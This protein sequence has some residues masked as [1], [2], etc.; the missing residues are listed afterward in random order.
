MEGINLEYLDVAHLYLFGGVK[1]VDLLLTLMALDIIT[2]LFKAWKNR[3]LWSRKSLFGYAR[4]LLVLIVIITA[5]IIDQVLSLNGT[6]TF[7][8]VLFYVANEAL[9]ITENMAQLGVL[10]PQNLAEKLKVIESTKHEKEHPAS[11]IL[12]ELAGK[13]VNK[14]LK[15]GEEK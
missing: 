14:K 3:N 5:N 1:F 7:A 4:K 9:S 8:T 15:D 2:G 12:K 10:V 13:D 6:L 11:E